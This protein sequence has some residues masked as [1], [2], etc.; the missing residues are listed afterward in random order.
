MYHRN[1]IHI[2]MYDV[3]FIHCSMSQVSRE[4]DFF[5]E[6][7]LVFNGIFFFWEKMYLYIAKTIYE[8][9]SS[10]INFVGKRK[11]LYVITYSGVYIIV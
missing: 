1:K 5:F 10:Y 9:T 4:Y 11:L 2:L 8:H 7:L 3:I 6:N